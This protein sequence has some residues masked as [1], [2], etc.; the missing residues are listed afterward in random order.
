MFRQIAVNVVNEF[1][2]YSIGA[3]PLIGER[4]PKKIIIAEFRTDL[5]KNMFRHS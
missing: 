3:I 2:V 5:R 1:P 4:F